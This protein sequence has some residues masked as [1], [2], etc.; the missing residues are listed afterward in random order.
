MESGI[1]KSVDFNKMTD[2]CDDHE[3]I[4]VKRIKS[5]GQYLLNKQCLNCGEK[6]GKAYKLNSVNNIELLPNYSEELLDEFY[7]KRNEFYKEKKESERKEW[8]V[9]YNIYL[10]SDKWKHKRSLV[11]KRDNYTCQSCLVNEAN[12]VHHL[13]YNHVF[14]EPLFELVS[15]CN[16]C[17]ELITKLDRNEN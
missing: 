13:T 1:N 6:E 12:E 9:G 10:K 3:L 4:F 5:N 7:F 8:F 11:L 14:D 16:K 15:I 17:H 2:F